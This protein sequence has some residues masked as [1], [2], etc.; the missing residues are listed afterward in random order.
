[1]SQPML[2]TAPL[3]PTSLRGWQASYRAEK[4]MA[5]PAPASVERLRLVRRKRRSRLSP[6]AR[7][8][9]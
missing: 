8:H 3:F 6:E 2:I 7:P 5:T 4:G 1:M 9:N